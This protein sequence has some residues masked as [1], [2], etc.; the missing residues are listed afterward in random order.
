MKQIA[1]AIALLALLAGQV[2]A[3]QVITTIIDD[4]TLT[5]TSDRVEA[6][7]GIGGDERVTFFVTY[8][9]DGS[10]I[11]VTSTVTVAVSI[12]GVNWQDIS[13]FDVAGGVTPQTSETLTTDTTYVGWL[14]SRITAKYIRIAVKSTGAVGENADVS[15]NLVEER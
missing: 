15:V 7:K 6:D 11:G 13:W 4:E 1:L 3:G 14:D 8:D 9:Q 5:G 2:Y 10:T 12:D